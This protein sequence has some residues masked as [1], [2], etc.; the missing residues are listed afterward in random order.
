VSDPNPADEIAVL[1]AEPVH[2]ATAQDVAQAAR[3]SRIMVSR[4]FNPDASIRPEKRR[5]TLDVAAALGYHPDMAARAMVTRRSKLVAVVVSS[6]ANSW[7]AQEID[8]LIGVLQQDGLS[9]LVFRV[10]HKS[11]ASLDFAHVKAYR[12]AAV[13]AY[14]D[15]LRPHLLRRAF[16]NSPALYPVYGAHPPE[17]AGEPLVDR[18]HI[19]QH[20]GIADA[21]RLL[22]AAGRSRLLYVQGEGAASDQDRLLALQQAMKEHGMRFIGSIDGRFDY[23]A[24]RA[25]LKTFWG[26]NEPPDAIF[27]ANDTSAFGVLDALRHDLGV[28]VPKAC[29]VVGFDNIR[30]AG[31]QSFDL[32]TVGVDLSERVRA[33]R[34]IIRRRA[35]NPQAPPMVE[36]ITARLVVR[37]TA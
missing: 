23:A 28:E 11:I 16:G 8:A 10:A 2:A 18:L 22:A 19:A 7:E 25:A 1:P 12:P 6:L 21:V 15:D 24:T 30:E 29:A 35:A 36:T 17:D 27:A 37:G 20:Q 4:A 14:M 31:W 26:G 3:V 32:T 9:V 34:G 13:I 33:I 5:H